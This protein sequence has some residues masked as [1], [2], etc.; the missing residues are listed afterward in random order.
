ML[1]VGIYCNES[2]RRR[3]SIFVLNGALQSAD[4]DATYKIKH[5]N[6]LLRQIDLAISHVLI[7]ETR[8]LQVSAGI[9]HRI[10]MV[11][12]GHD[13]QRESS[14]RIDWRSGGTTRFGRD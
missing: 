12:A 1:V 11:L 3:L 6:G 10:D 13:F 5:P 7:A 14:V 8:R 9:A 4:I 2:P